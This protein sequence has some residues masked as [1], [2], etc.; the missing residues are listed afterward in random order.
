MFGRQNA[1]QDVGPPDALECV[2]I[3]V[4]H[5]GQLRHP[6][7]VVDECIDASES[8]VGLADGSLN[9]CLAADIGRDGNR[10]L[11][12]GPAGDLIDHGLSALTVARHH[13]DSGTLARQAERERPANALRRTSD[14]DNFSR[15]VDV[16]VSS[17]RRGQASPT[18]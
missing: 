14:H 5:A 12:P 1:A 4:H 6:P 15:Q 16:H 9:V 13:D 2:D 8:A 10:Q 17:T 3:N 7:R 11:D 18:T